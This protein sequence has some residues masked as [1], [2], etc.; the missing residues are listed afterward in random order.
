MHKIIDSALENRVLVI[1]MLG[2]LVVGGSFALKN[3]TID[4][5]PDITNVQVQ[6]LTKSSSLGPVEVER[7]ITYPVE[8]AM[9]GL[10]NLSQIR[11]V[12]RYGISSVTVIFKEGVDLYFARQ[13]V[14]ERLNAAIESIPAGLGRPELGPLTTGLGEVFQFTVKGK[15]YTAMELRTILD[16]E[17]AY[18]LR[19][20][21]GVV[22]V[23]TWGGQ[24]QQYHVV[25]DPQRLLAYQLPLSV[26]FEALE[27]N[28]ANVG[29]GY[30]E[31]NQEQYMI[32][33]EAL[34]QTI[35]DIEDIMVERNKEGVPI[36]IKNI[37]TV[38]KGAMLRIGA[39]TENG[40][41]ETVIGMVQML[42]GGNAQVL[43]KRIK[44][45]LVEIQAS[46]PSGV[47]IRP[48]YDRAQFVDRVLRTV[49]VNL[50]EGGLLIIAVLFLLLGSFQGGLIVALAI[51]LSMLF[52]F[53][54]MYYLGISGNLMSLG[55]I[56]FGLLVDGSIVMVE[57]IL[58]KRAEKPE[59]S[60]RELAGMGGREVA[61]PVF[62]SVL[63]ITLVYLP[64]LALTGT[65]GKM[66]QPMAITLIFALLGSLIVAMLIMPVL[67]SFFFRSPSSGPPGEHETWLLRM[68]KKR[69]ARALRW[70]MS[71]RVILVLASLV[72]LG[73]AGLLARQLGGEFVPKLNEG[74]IVINVLRLP[75]VSMSESIASSLMIER[76]LKQFPEVA[77][78]V[79]RTGSPEVA[80]DLMGI[81][82]SDV[83]VMLRP[84]IKWKT[85]RTK[86]E[87]IEKMEDRLAQEI[88]G[89]GLSF[90]QPIEMR[91]NELISGV[92]S[93][94]GV[95]VFG[96]DLKVLETRAEQ[97][98]RTLNR[99]PGAADVRVEQIQGLPMARIV[100]DRSAIA[101]YGINAAEV[102]E[103]VQAIRAGKNVGTVY[104]G[105]KRFDLVVRFPDK[106]VRNIE[107]MAQL[108][109]AETNG[110]TMIPLGQLAKLEYSTGPAQIT[111]EQIQRR[112]VVEANVRGRDLKGFIREAKTAVAREVELEPG[113]YLEWGGQFKNLE[114]ASSHL[115]LVV[116][117]VL[118]LI[119]ALLYTA[120]K[121]AHVA[122]IIFLNVPFAATGGIFAL[123][124]CGLPFSI[125]AAVGF[126]AL[127]GVAVLNGVVL[128]SYVRNIQASGR[129]SEE[130]AYEGAL[131]RFRPVILTAL[132]AGLGFIPMVI[133]QG[134][135]A[136][137]QRPLATVVIGGLVTST[138]LTLLVLPTIYAWA[139]GDKKS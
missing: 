62:F 73:S 28:N 113:Y 50:V 30:I 59:A 15:G 70:T 10:P 37:G 129:S 9:S 126:I 124:F 11:S 32:R 1:L 138:M 29:S 95:K 20:V 127:F 92:R 118:V 84:R 48:F 68:T 93:D 71:H 7:L 14:S 108:P 137:V 41:H 91:F 112:I 18:R 109:V 130:A 119:F 17:I 132:V 80:T 115:L 106:A 8:A 131:V 136:E 139:F 87:L 43:V 33:G 40:R 88:P 121:S 65:E 104:E 103:T 116:P 31:R 114:R 38:E 55:A 111:R 94:I 122:L 24:A 51:P 135:G 12:S 100:I 34:I 26:V 23:N 4:A 13:L 35:P 133:S 47:V 89:V 78:V 128:M 5:I 2:F 66:F 56:D 81:E 46:L 120:F 83:F 44:D 27:K 97:I 74:D 3:L 67:A 77:L 123:A 102:L 25:I 110:R 53:I 105:R 85:A 60:I 117:L 49:T 54:G 90:T 107:S 98:A 72:V 69:Y 96:D 52:A 82:L 61:R 63:I 39:A 6:I 99:I 45:K 22:E 57:N 75:S 36:L 86:E 21:P 42:A 125:A 64:I 16:W 101:R 19:S 79:S 76:C 134:M 58:R